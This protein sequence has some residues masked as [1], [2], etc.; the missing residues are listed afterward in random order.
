MATLDKIVQPFV[1]MGSTFP[2]SDE[3]VMWYTVPF[4]DVDRIRKKN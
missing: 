1:K 2:G 4:R 3:A